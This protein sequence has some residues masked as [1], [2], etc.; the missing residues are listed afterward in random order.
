M[1]Q[2]LILYIP[3]LH[4]GYIEL[5]E[6]ASKVDGLFLLGKTILNQWVDLR[7]LTRE[8][9]AIDPFAMKRAIHALGIFPWVEVLGAK[10]AMAFRHLQVV[11]ADED[12]TRRFAEKYLNLRRVT[13]DTSFL[14]YDTSK[15]AKSVV[16][17]SPHFSRDPFHRRM[18]ALAEQEGSKSSCW[19]RQ[20]GIVAVKEKRVLL[21][22]Y[23]KAMPTA[24]DPYAFGHIRDL[25]KPGEKGDLSSTLHAEKALV[26]AAARNRIRLEGADVYLPVFPCPDCAKVLATA[27]IRRCF[28][29]SG[30][31]Y[32][33]AENV[34]R[35]ARIEMICVLEK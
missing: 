19:W 26:A 20:I 33:D 4:Q 32:L 31:A 7:Y 23:N 34:M 24:Y 11:T 17:S 28:F 10:K 3:V 8:I 14:R 21:A 15:L 30:N 13:F 29:R 16:L 12:I 35:G 9:R 6:R 27:G 1:T 22:A 25:L 5:F 2:V 18:M